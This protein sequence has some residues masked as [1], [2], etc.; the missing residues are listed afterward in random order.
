MSVFHLRGI[1]LRNAIYETIIDPTAFKKVYELF[2]KSSSSSARALDAALRPI[3]K[4]WLRG[5]REEFSDSF[6]DLTLQQHIELRITGTDI[7]IEVQQSIAILRALNAVVLAFPREMSTLLGKRS[8]ASRIL[9]LLLSQQVPGY[10]RM[11]LVSLVGRW[12]IVL[13]SC[14]KAEARLVAIVESFYLDTGA[15]PMVRFLPKVPAVIRL[16]SDWTYPPMFPAYGE[17]GFLYTSKPSRAISHKTN[18]K[19]DSASVKPLPQ[20]PSL[21]KRKNPQIP[22]YMV[23]SVSNLSSDT[24]ASFVSPNDSGNWTVASSGELGRMSL[25]AQELSAM[26]DMLVDNLVMMEPDEDPRT[27]QIVQDITQRINFQ[28]GTVSS[29]RNLLTADSSAVVRRLNQA[30]REAKTS[31]VVYDDKVKC[32]EQWVERHNDEPLPA[33]VRPFAEV[34]HGSHSSIKQTFGSSSSSSITGS[35][36]ECSKAPAIRQKNIAKASIDMDD[37]HKQST[38]L[39]PSAKVRGKMPETE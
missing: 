11:V 9:K 21:Y 15:S 34:L 6:Y 8:S 3:E 23:P 39:K 33:V 12:C 32:H 24:S 37:S 26:S 13:G 14:I 19:D 10:V 35:E 4:K 25:C 20:A 7:P 38:V 1:K 16:Q 22:K 30:A 36:A 2:E 5:R 29:Y 28:Y 17:Q 27:N 18:D 31:L